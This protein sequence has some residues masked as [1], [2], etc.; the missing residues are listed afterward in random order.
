MTSKSPADY[1]PQFTNERIT[2]IAKALLEQC[3]ATDDDLQSTYDSGYSIGCTRFDRQKNRLKEMALEHAWLNISDGSNRL[4][5]NINGAPFRFTRDDYLAPKKQSSTIVSRTEAIQIEKFSESQH[6]LGF[7]WGDADDSE[8]EMPF[9]WRFFVDVTENSEFDQRDYEIYFV[10]L[11][12]MDQISCVW[13]LSEHASHSLTSVHDE[14]PEAAKMPPA[15]T[16]LPHT[17]EHIINSDDSG[18]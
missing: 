12:F 9:K 3:Y 6:Q 4:V 15:Q 10:G 1:V 5:M 7:D 18:Q 11:N 14:K 16:T 8:S 17:K 13:Q 2:I